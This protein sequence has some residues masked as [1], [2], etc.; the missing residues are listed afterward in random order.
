MLLSLCCSPGYQLRYPSLALNI[1]L[2]LI[3]CSAAMLSTATPATPT[4]SHIYIN[5]VEAYLYNKWTK[6]IRMATNTTL[7]RLL[8]L[9][10]SR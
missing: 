6:F 2:L 5:A 7:Q 10:W 8:W 9:D 3:L 1:L 4:T